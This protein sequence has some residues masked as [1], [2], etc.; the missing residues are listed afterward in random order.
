MTSFWLCS[1]P[2]HGLTDDK[3]THINEMYDRFGPTPRICF[4]ALMTEGWLVTYEDD[5]QKALASLT[6]T[7]LRAIASGINV[8]EMDEASHK[9]FLLRRRV[10]K[11][12]ESR[13]LVP[14]TASVDWELRKRLQ[15]LREDEQLELYR[16][17]SSV[18]TSRI[19]A[20]MVFEAMAQSKLQRGPVLELIPME[21]AGS[22][23]SGQGG[24]APRWHS[25]HK[26]KL[27]P[28]SSS[29][30]TILSMAFAMTEVVEY[31]GSNLD[32]NVPEARNQVAFDSFMIKD[33]YLCIFL[34]LGMHSC[35]RVRFRQW[36]CGALSPL[37]Q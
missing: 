35:I 15:E 2:L 28:S 24:K 16:L 5:V 32:K 11:V 33:G 7:Q 30:S 1:A 17:Y 14:I 6:L 36:K 18:P 27:D 8:L 26:P 13:S 19:F 37:A 22:T 20:G 4:D 31:Q 9:I 10:D 23:S 3:R 25:K 29:Q 34:K 12:L 21:T